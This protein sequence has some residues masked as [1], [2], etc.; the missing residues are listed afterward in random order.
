MDGNP[1]GGPE[2]V[3]ECPAHAVMVLDVKGVNPDY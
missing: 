3:I 1:G 2:Y